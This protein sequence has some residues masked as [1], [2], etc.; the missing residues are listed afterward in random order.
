MVS[1][2]SRNEGVSDQVDEYNDACSHDYFFHVSSLPT[3]PKLYDLK[4]RIN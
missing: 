4:V 1:V 2:L 3:P